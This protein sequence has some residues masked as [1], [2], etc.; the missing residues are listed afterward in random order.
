MG[1][2]MENVFRFLV[3]WDP[4]ALT[5]VNAKGY[6]PLFYTPKSSIECFQ[7]VFEAGIRCFPKKKGISLL[8][9]KNNNSVP[10][11]AFE[12]AFE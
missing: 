7:S 12:N 10:N 2:F 4:T 9:L 5:G 6:T 11:T 3:D 8:F 1:T